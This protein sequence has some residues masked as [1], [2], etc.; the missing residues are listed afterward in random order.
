M[1]RTRFSVHN[2]ALVTQY[3]A[4]S[5][6]DLVRPRQRSMRN[7]QA[8]LFSGF[9]VDDQL[10]LCRLFDG[11]VGG[12]GAFQNLVHIGGGTPEGVVVA[13]AVVHEAAG[14]DI[15]RSGIDR[16]EPMF[17]C[18]VHDWFSMSIEDGVSRNKER[19]GTSFGGGSERC[20]KILGI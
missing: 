5:S 6:D 4:L 7:R 17:C 14:F 10:K 1:L 20:L 3:S 11:K 19:V 13:R 16:R 12:L 2:S 15:F 8:N 18:E 9:E